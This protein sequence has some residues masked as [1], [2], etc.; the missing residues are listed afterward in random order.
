MTRRSGD[1]RNTATDSIEREAFPR[2][3][4]FVGRERELAE[5]SSGLSDALGG[6]GRL[7]LIV[8]EPGIGKTRLAGELGDY[9][10]RRGARVP[11]GTLLEGEG[12]P[13]YWPWVQMLRSYLRET[14][15]RRSAW[16]MGSGAP[17]VAQIGARGARAAWC[18]SS[19]GDFARVRST[20]VPPLRCDR[21]VLDEGSGHE[22]AAPL[23][24][25]LDWADKASLLLLQ[26]VAH[27]LHRTRI[28]ALGTYRETEVRQAAEVMD[29]LAE[30][31]RDAHHLPLS[32]LSEAEVGQVIEAI[33]GR[34]ASVALTRTIRQATEGN[35]FFVDELVRLLAAEGRIARSEI[36]TAGAYPIPEGVREAI[37]RRLRPL[38]EEC[39]RILSVA[40][41]V[42]REFD[43]ATL[44]RLWRSAVERVL[45]L[46]G[47]ALAAGMVLE[48]SA[49]LGRFS[50]A[51]ALVR[52]LL[53]DD[54][55]PA[56]RPRGS[57]AASQR[58]WKLSIHPTPSP[59]SRSSPT[60][61]FKRG[62]PETRTRRST[63]RFAPGGGR[64]SSPMTKRPL[65]TSMRWSSSSSIWSEGRRADVLLSLGE[66]LNR[67]GDPAGARRSLQ[68][69]AELS[70]RLGDPD[71]LSRA[72]L[73][74][75]G[76]SFG[77]VWAVSRAHDEALVS[78]LEE[79]ARGLGS[80]DSI[81]RA[82]VLARLATVLHYAPVR[83]RRES[84]SREAVDVARAARRTSARSP[85]RSP[86][87][88]TRCAARATSGS[89][90]KS[91]TRSCASP[92]RPATQ[93]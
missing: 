55:G 46:L 25:D 76:G 90:L 30:V 47:E 40:C 18:S 27:G 58:P 37:R 35:P 11:L 2:S 17:D 14:D 78:L 48:T 82:R 91:P 24:D 81:L 77:G 65:T 38:S 60:I 54:L 88:T 9:A 92:N 83:E 66:T 10:S 87:A 39:R 59:I 21:D 15:P 75:G 23:L 41:V 4:V 16:N 84:L 56:E 42:G 85:M 71:R 70:R 93:S 80:A 28:L 7:L 74:F 86:H 89:D 61:S 69:A 64:R 36:L 45:V 73:G 1:W 3:T 20:P 79:A 19:S 49:P 62:R 13:P 57:T 8:G 26:F 51:H 63:T 12:A 67:A 29:V 22:D 50:F 44:Q 72:A 6:R 68:R 5:L 32:G 43:L 53:Y 31:G 33:A 52:E 34:P